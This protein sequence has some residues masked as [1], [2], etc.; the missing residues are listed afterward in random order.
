MQHLQV[1]ALLLR[2]THAAVVLFVA[3]SAAIGVLRC[4]CSPANRCGCDA[5]LQ[6]REHAATHMQYWHAQ[7]DALS[8]AAE[9]EALSCAVL[10]HAQAQT[11]LE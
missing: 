9:G 5:A 3:C 6:V 1:Q 4:R 8:A 11:V 10:R 7:L 2:T